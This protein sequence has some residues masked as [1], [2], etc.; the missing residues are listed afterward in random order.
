LRLALLTP[1]EIDKRELKQEF[2]MHFRNISRI[3]DCVGCEKCKIHG[4]LQI[5]GLGTALKILLEDRTCETLQRNEI[6]VR[7]S[8]FLPSFPPFVA[9]VC[10][11]ACACAVARVR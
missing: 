8:S 6:I 2:K 7:A 9:R 3:M 10:G 1:R 5:L 11:G 4:K